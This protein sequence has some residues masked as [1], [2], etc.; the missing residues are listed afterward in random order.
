M[1]SEYTG[2]QIL[3]NRPFSRWSQYRTPIQNLYLCGSSCRPG[4]NTIGAPSYNVVKIIAEDLK[5]DTWWEPLDFEKH[6]FRLGG[7]GE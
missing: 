1:I 6:L 5:I 7:N 3:E 4:G 2:D